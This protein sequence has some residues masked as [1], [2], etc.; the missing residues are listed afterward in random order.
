MAASESNAQFAAIW[1]SALEEYKRNTNKDP[2]LTPLEGD[3]PDAL[4]AIID[5]KQ[6]TFKHYRSKGEKI[7]KALKPILE[8]VLLFSEAAGEGTA[9]VSVATVLRQSL[10]TNSTSID[11]STIESNFCRH[12]RT[13]RS[14]YCVTCSFGGSASDTA[15][16]QAAKNVTAKY[17]AILDVF[18]EMG[19]FLDRLRVYLKQDVTAPMRKIFVEILSQ[20]LRTFGIFTKFMKRNR[21][22]EQFDG[23]FKG[24]HGDTLISSLLQGARWYG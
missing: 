4:L 21:L 24:L 1:A 14:E 2:T 10:V 12:S 15:P 9:L 5:E 22:S 19:N 20:M 13:T 6:R 11:I 3:S 8:L 16:S 7:R 17:D 18:G 23:A